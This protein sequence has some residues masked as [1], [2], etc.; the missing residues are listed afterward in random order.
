MSQSSDSLQIP[1]RSVHIYHSIDD[2]SLLQIDK[3]P[4]TTKRKTFST[5]KEKFSRKTDKGRHVSISS[6]ILNNESVIEKLMASPATK[7]KNET[8]NKKPPLPLRSSF[9]ATHK[10]LETQLSS[11]TEV[12]S[13]PERDRELRI[14]EMISQFSI[15][16]VGNVLVELGLDK[17]VESFRKASIDGYTLTML[18]KQILREEFG[19]KQ[20]EAIKLRNFVRKGHIPK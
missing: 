20:Y 15:N 18:T 7:P 8:K 16:D 9:R 4:S 13:R 19:L 6:P 14:E 12:I 11:S 5:L 3:V 2:L 1:R 10:E 17:F